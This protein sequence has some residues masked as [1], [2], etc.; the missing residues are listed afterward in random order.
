MCINISKLIKIQYPEPEK[1]VP[2]VE[3]GYSCPNIKIEIRVENV[4]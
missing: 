4:D 1:I 2:D 3:R